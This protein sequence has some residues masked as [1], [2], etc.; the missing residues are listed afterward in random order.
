MRQ[1]NFKDLNLEEKRDYI[2]R[3]LSPII[4]NTRE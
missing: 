2:R 1:I 3:L 4:E